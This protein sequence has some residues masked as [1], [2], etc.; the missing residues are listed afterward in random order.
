MR[1]KYFLSLLAFVFVFF[2]RCSNTKN[3]PANDK[4]YTGASIN[5]SGASSVREK[6]TLKE[7]LAG[8]TRPKPNSKVLGLRIKLS[9]YNAFRNKKPNSFWGRL[10]DRYGEP[11]VLL[12][13]VDLEQ[14]VKVLQSHL[15]NKGYFQAMVNSDTVVHRKT[16]S[17]KYNAKAGTQYTINSVHYPTDSSEL[18]KGILQDVNKTLLK[19]GK[20]YDLDVIKGER[21]RIDAALKEKGFYFFNQDYIIVKTDSTIGNHKVDMYVTIKPETP[22][23]AMEIYRIND[24]YIYSGYSL[25]T[26]KQDTSKTNAK[27]SN[28]YY[29]I[30]KKNRYK[31]NLFQNAMQ[32][33]SGDIYSRTDHNQTLNRLINLNMFKFVKNRFE[34]ANADSPLLNAYYYLTPMP[35]KSLRFEAT[36]INRSNNLNG[37]ELRFS[38]LNRNAFRGGEQVKFTAYVGS[39]VQFSGAFSGYNTY[40][41]GAELDFTIPRFV[42]GPFGDIKTDGGYMP[43]TTIRMGYDILQ[44]N[45]L[46]TLNSYR[47]E[48][49]YTWKPDIT[50]QHE[51][52]P[53][54]INYVQPLN[55]TSAYEEL[56]RQNPIFN[57]LILQ[58]FILGSNYQFTYNE[59]ASGIQRIN[60]FYFNGLVDL[61]GNIAGLLTHPD[62]K[63]GDTVKIYK[64]PFSQYF[65]FE[66]D[67][68]YYR[69]VGLKSTWASRFDFGYGYPY[70]NS[71][72]LPY[73][74]Q[75]FVGGTNSLRGFRSRSVG[76]GTYHYINPPNS[77]TTIIPDETGDVKLEV[78]TEYR[79]HI[80]G[81]L[82]GAIFIDAGN[83]W[84]INDSTYTQKP[85]AKFTGKFLN[86]LAVDVGVGLR[87][88]ITIF[89][90][91]LDLGFPVRKPWEQNPW[92]MR[93]I[94]FGNQSWRRENL[95]YNIGIGYPF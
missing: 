48:Y 26:G 69:K 63:H 90:I 4:L 89:V 60:S 37:S 71:T 9:I 32:F 72:Q 17:A 40:R 21:T 46:F 88:D 20:P 14:N 18:T 3:I 64:A 22:K 12:S 41:T 74:K 35:A 62:V 81:P 94:N 67:F 44:R 11:P 19:K 39:D 75:F 52:F 29:L 83:I 34:V 77:K 28:G 55:V 5:L 91:R 47:F 6:K 84:L 24:V 10:R 95:V 31:A 54:S 76:P 45:K 43:R 61:S 57:R 58:Q 59:L 56:V 16:A 23:T 38:W 92:V 36:A 93:Q 8:L 13:Q 70:G 66:T 49:G 7:D 2:T 85:G 53:I 78:N 79:P 1:T 51:L 42:V 30:D 86:Q 15:E 68:R 27:F 80:S 82:Y 73:I 50:K 65:K 87:L 25:N 33:N